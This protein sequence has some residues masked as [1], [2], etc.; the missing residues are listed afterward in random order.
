MDKRE[1]LIKQFLEDVIEFQETHIH[2][3]NT[4]KRSLTVEMKN[5]L[6]TQINEA[7]EYLNEDT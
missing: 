7:Y 5:F 3:K 4:S 1:K 6:N 2:I